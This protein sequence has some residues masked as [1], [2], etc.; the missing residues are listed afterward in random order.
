M[1][2]CGGG[3]NEQSLEFAIIL[4]LLVGKTGKW[5]LKRLLRRY[6]R[7]KMYSRLLTL[8]I[9]YTQFVNREALNG[10]ILEKK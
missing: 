10:K 8:I 4:L 1:L 3:R 5:L 2:K 7:G 6:A 9:L